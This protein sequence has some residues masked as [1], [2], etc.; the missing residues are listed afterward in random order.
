MFVPRCS[1][2]GSANQAVPDA[3]LVSG[4]AIAEPLSLYRVR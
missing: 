3:I 2:A 1:A 4:S